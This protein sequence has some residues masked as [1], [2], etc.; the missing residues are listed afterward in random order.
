[1]IQ[2]FEQL[3]QQK[4][5]SYRK[6]GQLLNIKPETYKGY[7]SGKPITSFKVIVQIEDVFHHYKTK[8]TESYRI[9]FSEKAKFL[10]Q[11]LDLHSKEDWQSLPE[12]DPILNDLREH[13]GLPRK[14]K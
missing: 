14:D 1:M 3:R 10:L 5:W 8:K 12:D 13:Y 7:V 4:E 11:T 6:T 9:W 2:K